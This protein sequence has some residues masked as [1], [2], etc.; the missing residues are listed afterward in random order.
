[1]EAILLVGGQGSRL[2]ARWPDRP[3]AL[4]PILGRPFLYWQ[5]T[6]LERAGFTRVLLALGH[7]AAE[8]EAARSN[9]R[10]GLECV[11]VREAEP[12]GTG[13]AL[14]HALPHAK[15][16]QVYVLNGDSHCPVDFTALAERQRTHG[17]LGTLVVCAAGERSEYGAL[18]LD[19]DGRI[20][21]FA[22]K[23][24]QAGPGWVN[25]GVYLFDRARLLGRE[26]LRPCSLE[27]ELL[28]AWVEA[29]LYAMVSPGP[30]I[31]IGTGERWMNAAEQPPSAFLELAL[32][33]ARARV[34][35]SAAL[36]RRLNEHAV[37]QT[38]AAAQRL[39]EILRRGG[40][41]LICGNGGSAAD[42]QH[43]A[44]ELVGRIRPSPPRPGLPAIALCADGALLTALGNDF[45][46]ERIYARQVEAL[47]RPGDALLALSTSGA[48]PN[49]LAALEVARARGLTTAALGGAGT[50]MMQRADL[51][52]E[53]PARDTPSIQEAGIVLYHLLCEQIEVWLAA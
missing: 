44:A 10:L 26:P 37:P 12:L 48:S 5:L 49:V 19:P 34:S 38:M 50:P 8:I 46:F 14:L 32:E 31:D 7:R 3:K 6:L 25:A 45:G 1:M 15:A 17:G 16:A 51:P 27:R 2:A 33:H 18:D 39:A 29:G 53:I 4:A 23:R 11:G 41:L 21:A 47:G 42:A 28:P 20:R 30:L 52:I 40:T 36:L 24:P 22:E 9:W 35:A 13:G 43:I